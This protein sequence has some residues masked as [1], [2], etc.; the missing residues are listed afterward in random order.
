MGTSVVEDIT[1]AVNDE[2]INCL[3]LL[4]FRQRSV[5]SLEWRNSVS[6]T[7]RFAIMLKLS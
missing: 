1:E 3:H 2:R 7:G 4:L 6:Q 5:I